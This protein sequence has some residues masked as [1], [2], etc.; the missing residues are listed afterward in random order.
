LRDAFNVSRDGQ[1]TY[2]DVVAHIPDPKARTYL[3]LGLLEQLFEV[4]GIKRMKVSCVVS[5]Y[6]AAGDALECAA[7]SENCH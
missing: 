3:L 2:Y 6:N 4:H 1:Y 5:P 7:R